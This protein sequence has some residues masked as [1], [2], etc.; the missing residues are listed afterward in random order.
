MGFFT[1]K[2]LH[3]SDLNTI[4]TNGLEIIWLVRILCTDL[5]STNFQTQNHGQ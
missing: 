4:H 1:R 3:L 2:E 5:S